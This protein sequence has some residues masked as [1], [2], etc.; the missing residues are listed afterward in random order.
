LKIFYHHTNPIARLPL[1]PKTERREVPE[2]K[3]AAII[4]WHKAD[5]SYSQIS[6][7]EALPHSTVFFIIHYI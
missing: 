1:K 3:R 4:T 7:F 2:T 6:I 5:K